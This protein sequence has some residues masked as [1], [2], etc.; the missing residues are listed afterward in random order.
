MALCICM[1]RHFIQNAPPLSGTGLAPIGHGQG[2][3]R[4]LS[5]ILH[6]LILDDP[7]FVIAGI[8]RESSDYGSLDILKSCEYEIQPDRM[9]LGNTYIRPLGKSPHAISLGL[10]LSDKPANAELI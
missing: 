3:E 5:C 8:S 6:L 10:V 4:Q 9:G 1:S 2:I 7:N